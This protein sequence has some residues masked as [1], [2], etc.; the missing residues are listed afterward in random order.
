VAFWKLW[1]VQVHTQPANCTD[2]A[3][4][5]SAVKKNPAEAGLW[6]STKPIAQDQRPRASRP[7][8]S[9]DTEYHPWPATHTP[10]EGSYPTLENGSTK[11]LN[12]AI[13][14]TSGLGSGGLVVAVVADQ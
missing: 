14:Y 12:M 2:Q 8:K 13:A 10:N 5:A 6:E 7:R 1:S 3:L 4:D 11:P 9:P